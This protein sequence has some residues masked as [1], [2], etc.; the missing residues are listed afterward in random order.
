[1]K[2]TSLCSSNSFIEVLI[3][4][5]QISSCKM[6]N[7]VTL[8]KVRDSWNHHPDPCLEHFH[9]P[10]GSIMSDNRSKAT[11]PATLICFL[12]SSS[13]DIPYK[14]KYNTKSFILG[15]FHF[16]CLRFIHAKHVSVFPP[17]F[18]P[19]GIWLFHWPVKRNMAYFQ[20]GAIINCILWTFKKV[21][22]YNFPLIS[23][24]YL[25]ANHVGSYLY[26]Q[27]YI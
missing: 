23:L 3:Y 26:T 14:W 12:S 6:Y 13:L 1:M 15:I 5:S 4:I 22:V 16:A 24:W 25:Q 11:G 20:I 10:K 18:M 19:Y 21:F 9:P 27:T 17:F 8:S 7:S 2:T